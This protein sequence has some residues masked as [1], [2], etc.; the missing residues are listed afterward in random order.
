MSNLLYTIVNEVLETTSESDPRSIA[1]E[2]LA[3]I[4]DEGWREVVSPA[5][6]SYVSSLVTRSRQ[7]VP[8]QPNRPKVVRSAKVAGIRD[9]W[10]RFLGERVQV[11]GTWKRVAECT[12]SDVQVLARERRDVAARNVAHAKRFEKLAK[13]M[14][15]QGALTVADF[16]PGA[17]TGLLAA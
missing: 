16:K 8:T 17:N 13:D 5:L 2:V 6:V 14:Q 3:S 11:E 12:V 15:A 9:D 1:A 4:P 7:G 10:Q